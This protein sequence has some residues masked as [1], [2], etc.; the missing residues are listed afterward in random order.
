MGQIA[1]QGR[2]FCATLVFATLS[3]CLAE[4]SAVEEEVS[5]V[6]G[7]YF[8]SAEIQRKYELERCGFFPEGTRLFYGSAKV[9][10]GEFHKSQAIALVLADAENAVLLGCGRN[11]LAR[12]D[13]Y[14]LAKR[15]E[16]ALMDPGRAWSLA[17]LILLLESGV[18]ESVVPKHT[19]DSALVV[20]LDGKVAGGTIVKEP[21]LRRRA[22]LIELVF[23]SADGRSK[24][25][26]KVV[27]W[28]VSDK[29]DKVD[30]RSFE[31]M[32]IGFLV[33]KE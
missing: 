18:R 28:G 33:P 22:D 16:N 19:V 11:A 4:E 21:R 29:V 15:I 26:R 32:P 8:E 23:F 6:F 9:A 2:A 24:L 12:L 14:L 5:R 25:R 17:T 13:S 10:D 30:L 31:S 7:E 1:L 20:D 3:S 27:C